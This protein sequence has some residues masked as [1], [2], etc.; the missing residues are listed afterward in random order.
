VIGV[1]VNA[2]QEREEVRLF[3]HQKAAPY[4]LIK[5]LHHSQQLVETQ[6]QGIVI[7][8]RVQHNYEL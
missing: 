3:V 7:S 1:T 5:P 8:L 2:Q 6:A 4:V